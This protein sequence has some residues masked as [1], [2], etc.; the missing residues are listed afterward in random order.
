MQGA[1][2]PSACESDS[3]PLQV[4]FERHLCH[5]D[6]QPEYLQSLEHTPRFKLVHVL[7]DNSMSKWPFKGKSKSARCD[8]CYQFHP[9]E[10]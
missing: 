9:V 1:Q 3:Y 4:S 2:I 6:I 10:Q 8:F 7:L 5:L